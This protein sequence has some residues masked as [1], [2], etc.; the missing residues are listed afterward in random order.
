MALNS[1]FLK[2]IMGVA[3]ISASTILVLNPSVADARE[4]KTRDTNRTASTRILFIFLCFFCSGCASTSVLFSPKIPKELICQQGN[5]NLSSLVFWS[6][7]WRSNQ[8]DIELREIAAENG[9]K[10]FFGSSN[11][12]AD[13]HIQR[14]SGEFK[15]INQIATQKQHTFNRVVTITVHELGPTLRFLESPALINGGTEVVLSI[16]SYSFSPLVKRDDFNVY[17]Q[18]GGSGVIKGVSTLSADME[19]AL[20]SALKFRSDH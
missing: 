11:C 3:T 10:N 19:G 18:N 15:E 1:K 6:T 20:A 16:T 13:I 12:F 17:W 9:I 4:H 7:S 14:T 2:N 8:K 5:E